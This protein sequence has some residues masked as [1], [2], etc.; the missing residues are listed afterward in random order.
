MLLY[1]ELSKRSTFFLERPRDFMKLQRMDPPKER[2][3]CTSTLSVTDKNTSCVV[4]FIVSKEYV[5]TVVG[6]LTL[7]SLN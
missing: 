2:N 6:T 7:K 5:A 3:E 1:A 4:A